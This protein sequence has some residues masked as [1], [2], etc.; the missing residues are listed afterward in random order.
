MG[1][2][3]RLQDDTIET[4]TTSL[5]TARMRT[6]DFSELLAAGIQIYNPYSAR[7][8]NSVVTRDPFPGNI[9]P[10]SLLNPSRSTS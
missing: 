2:Y 10:T 6:G 8:V 5:P 3:E 4:F 7:L 9:I 1:S